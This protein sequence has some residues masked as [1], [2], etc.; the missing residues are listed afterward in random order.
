MSRIRIAALL[1]LLLA[2]ASAMGAELVI[3]W[4]DLTLRA[5]RYANIPP[6]MAVRQMAVVHLAMFDSLDAIERRY[7]PY[8][9]E[10]EAP[11]ECSPEAGV[12]AAAHHVLRTLFPKSADVFDSHYTAI[13]AAIPNTP[14]KTN[15]MSWGKQVANE[16]LKLRQFD[17]AGQAVGFAYQDKPGY[18]ARTAPNFDKPLLPGWGRMKPFALPS[19]EEFRPPPA[20]ALASAEW[21]AEYNQVKLV[22][23]TNSTTRT[24]EQREIA[25]F[26]ADGPG[27]E[28]PPGHWNKIAHQLARKKG[29]DL[30]DAARLFAALNVTMADAGV[31]CWN[32]KYLY[33]WWRPITAIRAGDKDGN[34]ATEPDPNWWPLINTPPFPEHTSGHSTFS[35]AAAAVLTGLSGSDEFEFVAMSDGLPGVVR[36]FRR[37]SDAARE[38]GMS[39]IYGGIH[40][41]SANERGLESGSK[42]GTFVARNLFQPKE[43]KDAAE[44]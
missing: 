40:F 3:V 4:N 16:F 9:V 1:I 29:L 34:P 20:P 43:K 17:G 2:E 10:N 22:G 38:A 30:L 42:I 33:N 14:A 39:R 6:P 13:L 25:L 31:V 27:T 41:A 37:F 24:P 11:K 23:A 35:G 26:W 21:A 5:I 15:G 36:R 19:V 8:L 28:T 12:S 44:K 7:K 18:W 32:A